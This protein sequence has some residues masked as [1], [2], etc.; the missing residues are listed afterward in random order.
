MPCPT[1]DHT[2]QRIIDGTFWCPRC[3]TLKTIS[4]DHTEIDTPMLV[5]RC[6]EFEPTLG[7]I[8]RD[9][10]WRLLGIHESIYPPE[11]RTV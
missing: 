8:L 9:G 6:R 3:G 2:M 10:K 11:E 1:C 4:G 7:N 5:N